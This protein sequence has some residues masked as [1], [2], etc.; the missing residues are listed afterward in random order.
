I[1]NDV[2]PAADGVLGHM[3]DRLVA[4][5][6][7]VAVA[8]RLLYPR[9]KGPATGALSSPVD[10]SLQHRGIV[11]VTWDGIPMA[12]NLGRGED[13]L[14][15]AAAEARDVQAATA[16]CLLVRRSAF[17][18]AGGFTVGY[19]YGS[20]DVD[21]SLK[22]RAGGGRIVYEPQ[23]TFWHHESATQHLE[24]GGTRQVRQRANR[25]LLADL[26]GPRIFREVFLDRLGGGGAWSDG[27]LHVGV[28]LTRD[29]PTEGWGDWYTAHELGE[30]LEGLGWRVSYLERSG[31]HWYAPDTSIDVVVSL[32]D[33]FDVRRL[34]AGVVTVAWV[35]NWTDR[36][37]ERE[38]F[39][40]YDLVLASSGPSKAL[41]DAHSVHVARIMPIATN[42][43][44]FHPP[45]EP[46]DTSAA[47]EPAWPAADLVYTGNHWG[48]ERGIQAILP[49]LLGAGRSIALYGKGWDKIPAAASVALGPLPYDDLPAAYAAGAIVID[50]TAS[51]TLPYGAVNSRVFDALATGT[52][53][54]TDNVIGAQELFDDLLPAA[55]DPAGIFDLVE[56]YLADPEE[57]RRLSGALRAMV[58]ERHTYAHRAT[59]L[60]DH[61]A[62][63]ASAGHVDIAIGPPD[64]DVAP[65]WGD[66]HFGRALQR[67]LQRAGHPTRLRL[68]S[69]WDGVA[70]GRADAA[71][72]IFGLSERRVRPGQVS[73]LW[74]ISHPELVTDA[75]VVA[76][77]VVFVASDTFAATLAAR[78]GRPVTPLHQATD[79]ERFRPL[80]GGPVHELLF[81]ANSRGV[82]RPVVDELTPTDRDLAVFGSAWTPEL[83]DPRHL[84]GERI[85]NEELAAYYAAAKIVLNDHWGDMAAHGF[86]S[87][88]LYDAAASGAFVISDRVPG[89]DEEFDGGVVTFADGAEL[90][91]LVDRYLDAPDA[92][93]EHAGRAAAAVVGRHTFG[94]RVEQIMSVIEPAWSGRPRRILP[95]AA[96]AGVDAR[97]GSGAG[98]ISP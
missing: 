83:L 29:D 48:E 36:W 7:V 9:R 55:S 39:D 64:W 42:P 32:L 82:R 73:V 14:G 4:E 12:R 96:A 37:L 18:A 68:R 43:A 40:E 27:P 53:V 2:E 87:N 8:S 28:T 58:L 98:P 72:H 51:P 88:R 5:P 74:V 31:E 16:A 95:D 34:P 70:A 61:L 71:I 66:Y 33:A 22:L 69:A 45:G 77:D 46:G 15:P 38:W 20:E 65:R 63:W 19:D 24:E 81:V 30:A 60:R 75:M 1:N 54:V 79:P 41:I 6:N 91:D 52:L 94:H 92:R 93:T 89:I 49:R 90:R 25:E 78:T 17:D 84:R 47:T 3:V 85:P 86:L 97:P 35:R 26:W 10:L 59:E 67:A 80:Q 57:R 11:F 23:A 21:L 76:H 50:D 44:R 56:R 13:P 62:A